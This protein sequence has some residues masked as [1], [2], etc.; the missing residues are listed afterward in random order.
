M[1]KPAKQQL[2]NKGR[3]IA[4]SLVVTGILLGVIMAFIGIARLNLPTKI[5]FLVFFIIVLLWLIF[6][7]KNAA[8]TSKSIDLIVEVQNN[9]EP[10][11]KNLFP[12]QNIIKIAKWGVAT[13][14]LIIVLAILFEFAESWVDERIHPSTPTPTVTPSAT[15]TATRP[16]SD[17]M[18]F[19]IILDAS[20]SMNNTFD[21]VRKWDLATNSVTTIINSLN[22]HA[23]YS[24]FTVGGSSQNQAPDPCLNPSG[25]E[26]SF[27]SIESMWSYMQ[28]IKP[29]GGGS[30]AKAF[31]LAKT[32]LQDLPREDIGTIILVT[33]INDSCKGEDALRNLADA[34]R[35]LDTINIRGEVIL[36]DDDGAKT[37]EIVDYLNSLSDN[38]NVQAPQSI[39][40]LNN[41]TVYNVV[42]NVNIFIPIELTSRAPE[43]VPPLATPITNNET[44][45]P[46]SNQP[47]TQLL[48]SSTPTSAIPIPT[49]TFTLIP[50]NTPTP[51]PTFSPTP[52]P[53]TATNSPTV[54]LLSPP[55]Y[56]GE[57]I[58]CQ[59]NIIAQISGS[60]ATGSFHVW[61]ANYGPEGDTYALTTLSIGTN[62]NNLVTLGGN[63]PEYYVHKV[64]FEY[65]GKISNILDNLI[66][67]GL[68]PP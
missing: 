46:I 28:Q 63:L 53:P 22:S 68:S 32:A 58:N 59:I 21:G 24:L 51:I 40:V 11:K 5:I 65:D 43:V 15:A 34:I 56:I 18:Y 54:E 45:T 33:S 2:K 38:I 12:R 1:K 14:I 30:L 67:P 49:K 26:V 41:V 61:N 52:P 19:S 39:Y 23:H 64:W 3:D 37:Q 10:E 60:P 36:L 17:Y 13:F 27:G 6:E 16:A 29:L 9:L 4:G 47:P 8:K 66:C 31:N 55:E 20:E 50:T 62:D 35:D 25:S 7:D 57:G 44:H 42:N 48:S